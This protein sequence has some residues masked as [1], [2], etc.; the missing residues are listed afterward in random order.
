MI[1]SI[2]G[3]EFIKSFEGLKLKFYRDSGG[4]GT[5]GFGHTRTVEHGQVITEKQANDLFDSDI[6]IAEARMKGKVTNWQL[7]KQHEFDCLVSLAFNLRSFNKLMTHLNFSR[8]KFL[9]KIELYVHD[10]AGNKLPGL[11]KRRAR[12]KHLF[13]FGKYIKLG[14]NLTQ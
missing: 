7:L 10:I 5:I 3:K 12:E 4:V 14:E 9:N 8:E 2:K 11:V 13:V 6:G 1:T